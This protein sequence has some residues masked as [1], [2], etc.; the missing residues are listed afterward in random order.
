MLSGGVLSTVI[1]PDTEW[2][3]ITPIIEKQQFSTGAAL[4]SAR[5]LSLVRSLTGPGVLCHQWTVGAAVARLPDTEEATGS[6]P[7]RSTTARPPTT[8]WGACWANH[9]LLADGWLDAFV[10]LDARGRQ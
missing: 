1:M 9:G 8:R 2:H 3:S 10:D 7:V 5:T 4:T 6:I